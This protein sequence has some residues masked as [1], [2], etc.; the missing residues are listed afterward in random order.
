MGSVVWGGFD[1]VLFLMLKRPP[2]ARV[3]GRQGVCR[4]LLRE[5]LFG[6]NC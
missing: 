1:S 4:E 3:G 6:G 2:E 5:L